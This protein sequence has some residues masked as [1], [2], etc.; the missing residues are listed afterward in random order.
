[1]PRLEGMHIHRTQRQ[2]SSVVVTIP[3]AVR[4]VLDLKAGDYVV[5]TS[6]PGTNVTELRKFSSEVHTH[7]RNYSSP[8]REA[9]REPA[10]APSGG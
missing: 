10:C 8:G 3:K 5:F 4:D 1:M 7:G 6:H 2:H 9:R